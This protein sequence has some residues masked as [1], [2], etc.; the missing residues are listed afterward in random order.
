MPSAGS[1][2]TFGRSLPG[3]E[4]LPM[5][6]PATVLAT[7]QPATPATSRPEPDAVRSAVA[8]PRAEATEW[9]V[10][11]TG[12][13]LMSR[14]LAGFLV[15]A[16]MI[17]LSW[18]VPVIPSWEVLLFLVLV[19]LPISGTGF[20]AGVVLSLVVPRHARLGRWIGTFVAGLGVGVVLVG[21][22]LF[23]GETRFG[24][25]AVFSRAIAR[26]FLLLGIPALLIGHLGYVLY[27]AGIA[28]RFA[29]PLLARRFVAFF[30][31]LVLQVG[32][33]VVAEAALGYWKY[34]WRP[35]LGDSWKDDLV[36][37]SAA[38]LIG[39][40]MIWTGLLWRLRQCI[41]PAVRP[42][43]LAE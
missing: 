32:L 31:C 18:W 34:P 10:V 42:A 36:L 43:D 15:C 2:D 35:L 27:L 21:A 17:Y 7:T 33:V 12:L 26:I 20:L 9:Q 37:A 5:S 22:S 3:K 40:G 38:I 11:R 41:P 1:S 16:L 6:S 23:W 25:P 8:R 24:I 4:A 39:M 13:T 29:A 19:G 28:R 14:S 30:A